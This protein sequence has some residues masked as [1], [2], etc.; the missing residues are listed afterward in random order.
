MLC[1]GSSKTEVDDK[2]R[3]LV[4]QVKSEVEKQAN[5]TFTVFEPVEVMQQVV[6]FY[7]FSLTFRSLV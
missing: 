1:G 3:T 7:L 5:E 6:G 2:I 4:N